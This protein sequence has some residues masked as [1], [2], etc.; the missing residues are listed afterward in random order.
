MNYCIHFKQLYDCKTVAV[1][2][3]ERP[4]MNKIKET[5]LARAFKIIFPAKIKVISEPFF[6]GAIQAV[7]NLSFS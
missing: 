6:I 5:F 7:G 4:L 1:A 3:F 2:L